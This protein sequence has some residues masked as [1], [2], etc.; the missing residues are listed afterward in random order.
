[1]QMEL[2]EKEV[3]RVLYRRLFRAGGWLKTLWVLLPMVVLFIFGATI[4]HYTGDISIKP[5]AQ[6]WPYYAIVLLLGVISVGVTMAVDASL[7]KQA[8][9]QYRQL[10]GAKGA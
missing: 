3:K 4:E 9:E 1:M 6:S 5:F 10:T 2:T 8:T 7:E